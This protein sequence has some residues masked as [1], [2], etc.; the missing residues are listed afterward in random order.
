MKERDPVLK[1][2]ADLRER[3]LA[4]YA[5]GTLKPFEGFSPRLKRRA[6][7][8]F[9]FG[10]KATGRVGEILASLRQDVG[11]RLI[12]A[13]TDFP[14]HASILEAEA[15][16]DLDPQIRDPT[17]EA[18]RGAAQDMLQEVLIRF[19]QLIADPGGSVI[20][21]A[22]TIPDEVLAARDVVA[23]GY[24]QAN[25]KPLSLEH[26]LHSTQVRLT[27]LPEEEAGRRSALLAFHARIETL[28]ARLEEDPVVV[29]IGRIRLSQAY[30][31]LTQGT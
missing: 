17:L 1:K 18:L 2:Y 26:I 5:N 12:G 31:F 23:S 21:A 19:D 3:G 8:S 30:A 14:L 13:G 11:I 24:A 6:N 25:L 16:K 29:R 22:R 27:S 20:L 10:A 7:L 9:G 4:A 28:N 15:A